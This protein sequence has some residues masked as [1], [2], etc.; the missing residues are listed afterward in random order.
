ML[1]EDRQRI[2]DTYFDTTSSFWDDLYEG[3]NL[4]SIIHQHRRA[5]ALHWVDQLGLRPGARVLEVGCGAGL[6]AVALARRGFQVDA[7]DSSDLMIEVAR[8]HREEAGLTKLVTLR[9]SDVHDLA[10]D[11]DVFDLVIGLGVIPWLHS[12]RMALQEMSRTLK[13]GG[14]LIVNADNA[15]RLSNLLDPLDNPA[16][17]PAK[18]FVNARLPR[19]LPND[20]A[21]PVVMHSLR[22]FDEVLDSVGLT[23]QLASTYGFGPITLFRRRVLPEAVGVRLHRWLQTRADR[24][25]WLIRSIG[26]QYLVLARKPESPSP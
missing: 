11:A 22:A 3:N 6:T 14:Y 2:V 12:P 19:R 16:L 24:R 8:G 5:L 10:Y 17:A 13:R 4:Y 21:P 26:A 18:R 15:A 23:K 25:V 7:T 20:A 9:K 1:Q